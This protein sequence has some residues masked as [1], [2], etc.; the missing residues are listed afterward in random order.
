MMCNG[1]SNWKP[2]IEMVLYCYE[3]RI[4]EFCS[5]LLSIF[6]SRWCCFIYNNNVLSNYWWWLG[7]S[8][9]TCFK[10]AKIFKTETK[11]KQCLCLSFA[12]Q[13]ICYHRNATLSKNCFALFSF[14]S[15]QMANCQKH[16]F[17]YFMIIV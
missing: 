11:I 16:F 7:V 5:V 8:T 2:A 1:L 3:K 6:Q 4:I 9:I 10:L 13:N 17:Q 14:M 15:L 12:C